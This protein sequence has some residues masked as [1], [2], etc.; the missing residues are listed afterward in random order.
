MTGGLVELAAGWAMIG[1]GL[2][3]WWRRRANRSGLLLAAAGVAWFFPEWNNPGIEVG[4]AFTFGL[5]ASAM[6]PPL[7]AHAV[8]AYPFGRLSS[9]VERLAVTLAYVDMFLVLGFVPALFFDPRRQACSLC[10]PNLLLVSSK[11]H[12]F[13][14]LLSLIHI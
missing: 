9:A 8:L 10:P 4:V 12:L 11:P 5:V 7:L 3:V 6:A 1:A 13:E 14:Y 2:Y